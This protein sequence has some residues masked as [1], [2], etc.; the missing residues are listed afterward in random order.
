MRFKERQRLRMVVPLPCERLLLS[1]EDPEAFIAALEKRIV[2]AEA[3][4]KAA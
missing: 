4:A 3:P 1:L 2:T